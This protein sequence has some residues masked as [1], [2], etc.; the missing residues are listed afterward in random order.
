MTA[1]VTKSIGTASRT[2]SDIATWES[3]APADLTTSE[4]WTAGTFAGTFTQ[5]E[6][7]TGVGLTDGKFL[8]SDQSSYV[9]F[10]IITGNSATLVTLTGTSS[11]AT[12]VVATKT[13]TGIVWKGEIY[14]DSE[15][16]SAS[17]IAIIGST[18]SASAYKELTVA[19]GNSFV[20]H[21]NKLTNPLRYNQSVGA[22]LVMTG[23]HFDGEL[24]IAET[25]A[26]LSRM[27]I[28][29]TGGG[30]TQ[31]VQVVSGTGQIVRNCIIEKIGTNVVCFRNDSSSVKCINCV[32]V[33]RSAGGE[34]AV[35]LFFATGGGFYNCT[36]VRPS[37]LSSGGTGAVISG[38]TTGVA[39]NCSVFGFATPW[40][41]TWDAAS[42]YNGSDGTAPGSNNQNSLTYASQFIDAA[43]SS[44]DFRVKTG[45]NLLLNGTRDA[46]NTDDLDIVGDARSVTT[47]TIGAWESAIT[48]SVAPTLRTSHSGM[49]W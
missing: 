37:G 46:A 32:F 19:A 2:Y 1:T 45:A 17:G 8:D 5:G 42:G 11:G 16:S 49:V 39:L 33:E 48:P 40:S 38:T 27:Q 3:G 31:A 24:T 13:D 26:R 43:D 10:G 47:P 9:V 44:R 29:R 34:S 7:V 20:D 4:R 41:G 14:N 30:S 35:W 22:G 28:N 6:Q 21:A 23:T 15:L 25:G 18:V 12:C 36:I